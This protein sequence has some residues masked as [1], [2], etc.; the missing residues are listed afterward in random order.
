MNNYYDIRFKEERLK[1]LQENYDFTFIKGC[2][3]DKAH[4]DQ[5]FQQWKPQI[6]V[7][8]AAHVGV[9]YSITNPDAYIESNLI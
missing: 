2:I 8:L 9:R 5:I 4:I 3:A 7:N 1:Q 6:V